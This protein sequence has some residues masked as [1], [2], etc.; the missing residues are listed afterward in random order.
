MQVT[1]S[2]EANKQY[3]KIPKQDKNKVKKKLLLLVENSFAGKK[4]SG[5]Y[6]KLRSLKSWPYRII[7]LILEKEKEVWIVSILHRQGAYK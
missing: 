7:Y 4:L 3:S 1:L 2:K 6:A 5:K